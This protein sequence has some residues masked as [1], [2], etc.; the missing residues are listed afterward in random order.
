MIFL[1]RLFVNDWF[2]SH[3]ICVSREGRRSKN[4]CHIYVITLLTL[5]KK[6]CNPKCVPIYFT[7][8]AACRRSKVL[9]KYSNSS[10]EEV[11]FIDRETLLF[12]PCNLLPP[13]TTTSF[14]SSLLLC[15]H[16]YVTVEKSVSWNNIKVFIHVEFF[17]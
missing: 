13:T 6:S 9:C 12:G 2:F 15:I 17:F 5:H 11:V 3:P 8:L 14:S 1:A 4:T 10:A 7:V 16:T